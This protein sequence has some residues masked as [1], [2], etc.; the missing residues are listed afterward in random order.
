MIGIIAAMEMERDA[1]CAKMTD[2]Q[3][4][5]VAERE[6]LSGKLA[7]KDTV[8]ALSGVGK[9]AAAISAT[10]MCE[11]YKPDVLIHAG[12]AGGLVE[13]QQ[14]GD[15]VISTGAVIAD[16]DTS[17]IDGPD[18]IGQYFEADANLMEK[19]EQAA[20][21][22]HVPYMKGLVATQDLFVT[23]ESAAKL[24]LRF[25]DSACAEMEGGAA[26]MTAKAFGIPF[27][28]LR[29]LSDVAVKEGNPVEFSEFARS[30]SAI[31]AN[32][33]ETMAELL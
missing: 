10:L 4:K 8:V 14:P 24:L 23:K 18:G 11:L 30:S 5:T 1:I 13:S 22:L 17:A 21:K 6:F 2:L 16:Y 12:V 27:V 33:V 9:V 19:A 25:E 31:A 28:I 29:S 3:K 26:A 15:L 32:L 7:G 20:Q